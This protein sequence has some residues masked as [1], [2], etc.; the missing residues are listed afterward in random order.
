MY[1]LGIVEKAFLGIALALDT[2]V[3]GLITSAYKIFMA[4]ASAELLSSEAYQSIAEKV[5]VIIGVGMLFVLAYA[6]L[7]AIIDPDQL[8]KGDMAGGKMLKSIAICVIGLIVTPLI[9]N[10]AYLAQGKMLE[11]D[12]L[13]KL[14]FR[15]GTDKSVVTVEG[16]GDVNFDEAL[17]TT[18]GGVAATSVWM[19]FF[20]PADGEDPEEIIADPDIIRLNAAAGAAACTAVAVG[21]G[22]LAVGL[23][24]FTLGTSLLIGGAVV[25]A[26]M[27]NASNQFEAADQAEAAMGEYDDISLTDAYNLTASGG[28]FGIYQ[29]FIDPLDDDKIKYTWF[30]STVCG[31]FVA[32]AFACYAIDMGVRAAKLA[33]Y[34]I[35]APIPLILSVL[36][37]NGDRVGKYV[38]G[39]LTTF[40]DVF[41]RISVVY[42]TIYIIAHLNELFSS[43]GAFAENS[44]LTD[45][46]QL[47]ALALLI[48]GLVLFAKQAP[49]FIAETFGLNG[50]VGLDGL[51]LM[52]KLR[53]GEV[54]TAGSMIGSSMKSGVQ[55]AVAGWKR[56]GEKGRGGLG[57]M[58]GAMGTA[59]GGVGSGA[60]RSGVSRFRNGKPVQ[61][62][63]DMNDNISKT[64][65]TVADKRKNRYDWED[66]NPEFKD[67]VKNI[68]KRV[69]D[70]AYAWAVGDVDL[71]R[72]QADIKF[73]GAANGLIDS[74]REEAFKKDPTTKSLAKEEERLSEPLSRY[75]EGWSE[76]TRNQELRKRMDADTRYKREEAAYIAAKADLDSKQEAVDAAKEAVETARSRGA[77]AATISALEATLRTK[78]GEY[79]TSKANFDTVS[80]SFESYRD[81]IIRGVDAVAMMD[82]EEFAKASIERQN[83]IKAVRD[84]KEAAADAYVAEQ[85][86]D[87][88]SIIR[89]QI[90]TFLQDNSEYISKNSSREIVLRINPDGT[91]EKIKVGDL[92]SE[93]FG[94]SAVNNAIVDGTAILSGN[95]IKVTGQD[96]VSSTYKMQITRADD[97]K[98]SVNYV[99]QSNP[100]ITLTKE[101]FSELLVQSKSAE[102]DTNVTKA[103]KRGKDAKRTIPL[104][105]EYMD[106]VTRKRKEEKK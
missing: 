11:D 90:Q 75:R 47:I 85:L 33:Y 101:Q 64:S 72:E 17:H 56:G 4:I 77:D 35:I 91:Q 46:E 8:S 103:G 58:V 31:G 83:K 61:N 14:F 9:F 92:I 49:K 66:E 59:M 21:A 94:A 52:K 45:V 67:K 13:G 105:Q 20:Y 1:S 81:G 40:L 37:K 2:F 32:Y 99:D 26:C 3:Y 36:P 65:R 27:W 106:K 39:V 70:A 41:V 5:Y 24:I 79:T 87:P 97:G 6:I 71:S 62:F 93:A 86:A 82:D 60:V 53:D 54:F 34:Q 16:V 100:T 43:M 51:N 44:G 29:G 80:G 22:A 98:I 69:K 63:K 48:I 28:N 7:K 104:T 78:N 15:T 12:I 74:T 68:G 96:D 18:G 23:S 50:N 84:K 88:N 73:A 57:K 76:E 38:K 25:G 10:L 55:G 42:I 95:S 19:A 102:A 30:V 89:N